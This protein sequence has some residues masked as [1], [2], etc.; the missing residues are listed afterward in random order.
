MKEADWGKMIE[1]EETEGSQKN[2][3]I[4]NQEVKGSAKIKASIE[5]EESGDVIVH[6]K[7]QDL[8]I[9][10]E[11]FEKYFPGQEKGEI[12]ID[13]LGPNPQEILNK[14]LETDE[15]G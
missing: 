3:I 12:N 13:V 6:I 10:K 9:S 15:N 14:L 11:E 2:E 8:K 5:K 4:E 7:E 1:R